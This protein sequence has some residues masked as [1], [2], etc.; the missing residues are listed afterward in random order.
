[1]ERGHSSPFRRRILRLRLAP[2]P[3]FRRWPDKAG[4]CVT[5]R[6]FLTGVADHASGRTSRMRAA[7]APVVEIE[8]AFDL[9]RARR[10]LRNCKPC[11]ASSPRISART[12]RSPF[13]FRPTCRRRLALARIH[14]PLCCDQ[15]IRRVHEPVLALQSLTCE[16]SR[17]NDGCAITWVTTGG[18]DAERVFART[19]ASFKWLMCAF[20]SRERRDA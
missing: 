7:F 17:G 2:T 9:L 6:S 16:R 13:R 14:L 19:R 8:I 12:S 3:R 18:V 1:M 20:S 15:E 4:A 5:G 11:S 10:R